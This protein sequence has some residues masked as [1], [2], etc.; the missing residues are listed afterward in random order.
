MQVEDL[1]DISVLN[2]ALQ[3]SLNFE[4]GTL[5][6]ISTETRFVKACVCGSLSLSHSLSL[7]LSLSL[8][9]CVCVC[10]CRTFASFPHTKSEQS[11][12]WHSRA[13]AAGL[14]EIC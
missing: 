10:V 9:V 3:L 13:K 2:H 5:I 1:S 11:S 7:S 6:N 8:C 14:F 4:T 12:W